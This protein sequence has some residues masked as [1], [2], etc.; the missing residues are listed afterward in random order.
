MIGTIMD[1]QGA[2]EIVNFKSLYYEQKFI[3]TEQNILLKTL[4]DTLNQLWEERKLKNAKI[5]MLIKD[6]SEMEK[7][8]YS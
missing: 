1:E 8:K 3:L 4:R 5:K 7:E 6:I 2:P